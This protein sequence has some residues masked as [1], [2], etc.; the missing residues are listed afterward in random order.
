MHKLV[1]EGLA[2]PVIRAM[3][4]IGIYG[5]ESPL[6]QPAAAT[7]P[8]VRGSV[9]HLPY[10]EKAPLSGG[11]PAKQVRGRLFGIYRALCTHKLV[12]TGVLCT[13]QYDSIQVVQDDCIQFCD[14]LKGVK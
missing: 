7:S 5:G 12:G 3:R 6:R 10:V 11:A 4:Q 13:V 14:I 9:L 2:P 1:G 8:K